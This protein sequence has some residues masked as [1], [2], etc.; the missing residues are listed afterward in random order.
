[1]TRTGVAGGLVP[2]MALAQ[3]AGLGDLAVSLW[4]QGFTCPACASLDKDAVWP[5]I[6]ATPTRCAANAGTSP[7]RSPRAA[8]PAWPS[9]TFG[10]SG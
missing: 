7:A 2:V 10:H 6:W 3:R 9:P 4:P 8:G 1:M 5:D